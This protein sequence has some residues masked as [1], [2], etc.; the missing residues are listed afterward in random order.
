MSLQLYTALVKR[1]SDSKIEDISMLKNSFSTSAFFFSFF[2]FLVH[3]M[4]R[5]AGLVI[6]AEIFVLKLFGLGFF[7]SIGFFVIQVALMFIIGLNATNWQGRYLQ[8]RRGYEKI[9]YFLAQNEEEARLKSMKSWHRN[10]P[11][12]SFDEVNLDVIDPAF[13]VKSLKRRGS[14]KKI[15][16]NDEKEGCNN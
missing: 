13:Y 5:E 11:E 9:G 15:F 2:W 10:S 14:L 6:L 3:T 16:K 1:D 8:K 4:W 12:L 7:G